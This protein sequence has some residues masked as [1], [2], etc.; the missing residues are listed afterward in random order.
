[1]QENSNISKLVNNN[2]P[3]TIIGMAVPM[4]VR[5]NTGIKA[6]PDDCSLDYRGGLLIDKIKIFEKA[7]NELPRNKLPGIVKLNGRQHVSAGQ[8][9]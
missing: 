8:L 5:Q 6:K 9:K 4:V 2:I 3:R 1:M 7:Y